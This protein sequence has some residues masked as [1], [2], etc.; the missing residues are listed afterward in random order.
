M[1]VV[2]IAGLVCSSVRLFGERLASLSLHT[3]AF[4]S[5]SPEQLTRTER[6]RVSLHEKEIYRA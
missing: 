1:V 5:E 6:Q 3:R 2:T 4:T